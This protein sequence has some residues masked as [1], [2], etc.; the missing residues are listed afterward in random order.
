MHSIGYRLVQYILVHF[1]LIDP[2]APLQ[3]IQSTSVLCFL[4]QNQI[5]FILQ[6]PR[7]S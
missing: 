6:K 3:S 4:D 7:S 1:S 2:F 5:T